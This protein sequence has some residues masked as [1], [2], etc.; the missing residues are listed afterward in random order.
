MYGKIIIIVTDARQ[1]L[2]EGK[3]PTKQTNNKNSY[4]YNHQNKKNKNNTH[5][6]KKQQTNSRLHIQ[7]NAQA[8]G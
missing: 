7:K 1:I 8:Q 4:I 3:N 6:K 2:Q 5:T